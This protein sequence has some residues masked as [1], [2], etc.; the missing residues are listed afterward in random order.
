MPSDVTASPRLTFGGCRPATLDDM[1]R[2]LSDPHVKQSQLERVRAF[3][4][5]HCEEA[6][7]AVAKL[8]Q[9]AT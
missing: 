9:P 5:E 6:N 2:L 4:A 3:Q 7:V 1:A 8:K